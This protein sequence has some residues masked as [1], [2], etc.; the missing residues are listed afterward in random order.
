MQLAIIPEHGKQAMVHV[1]VKPKNQSK[2]LVFP[3]FRGH[4]PKPLLKDDSGNVSKNWCSK[5]SELISSSRFLPY[6]G[7]HTLGLADS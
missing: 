3:T 1:Q 5:A 4:A 7:F 2:A 6:A